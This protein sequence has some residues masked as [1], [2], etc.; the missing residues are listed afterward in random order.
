MSEQK[1]NTINSIGTAIIIAFFML[2]VSSFS[3]K[4]I[5]K[6]TYSQNVLKS[7]IRA[8]LAATT[9]ATLLPTIQKSFLPLLSKLF[10][11]NINKT[12]NHD[13]KIIQHFISLQKT[14]QSIKPLNSCRFYYHFFSNNTEDLPILS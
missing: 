14:L 2:L 10:N 12:F 13:R 7:E 5:N 4:T 11:D 8:N 1:R 9:D 6:K 3:D